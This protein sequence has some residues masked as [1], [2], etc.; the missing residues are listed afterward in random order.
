M[1]EE[2][3][4]VS[5]EWVGAETAQ[6]LAVNKIFFMRNNVT[7]EYLFFLGYYA[8]PIGTDEELAQLTSVTVPIIARLA[9]P[10]ATVKELAGL[11]R[12]WA[13]DLAAEESADRA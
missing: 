6:V 8:P 13:D 4:E 9:V 12:N 1:A 7:D 10:S 5:I 2:P 11:F 3:R